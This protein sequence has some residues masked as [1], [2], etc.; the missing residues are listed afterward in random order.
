MSRNKGRRLGCPCRT[1][2]SRKWN[3][4]SDKPCCCGYA[5]NYP[6]AP[7]GWKCAWREASGHIPEL[8][9]E[10]VSFRPVPPMRLPSPLGGQTLPVLRRR[11]PPSGKE[12]PQGAALPALTDRPFRFQSK[13]GAQS[14]WF[15]RFLSCRG[16]KS[17]KTFIHHILF[18]KWHKKSRK[19]LKDFLQGGAAGG[20]L[21]SC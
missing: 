4:T 20:R 8:C 17:C 16:R 5:G 3:N 19:P 13:S 18:E 14:S 21:V 2:C 1:G 9:P 12:A 7:T 11:F 6:V 15:Q 10:T